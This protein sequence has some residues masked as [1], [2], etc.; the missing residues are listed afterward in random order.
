MRMSSRIRRLF[1]GS[2]L[3]DATIVPRSKVRRN[4]PRLDELED[5]TAPAVVT[6]DGGG[7]NLLWT[8]VANWSGNALPTANDEAVISSAAGTVVLTS[9]AVNVQS[10]TSSVGFSITGSASLT[11][12]L[13][14]SSVASLLLGSDTSLTATGATTT[15]TSAGSAA[16]DGARLFATAGASLALPGLISYTNAGGD[17]STAYFRADGPGSLLDLRNVASIAGSTAL[18]TTLSV[19]AINGGKVDLR[20]VANVADPI[21]GD[22]RGRATLFHADGLNSLVDL[23]ALTSFIDRAA[24]SVSGYP[25]YSRLQAT[26]NGTIQTPSLSVVSAAEILVDQTGHLSLPMLETLTASTFTDSF[27]HLDLPALESAPSSSFTVGGTNR[28]Y[29]LLASTIRASFT[30]NGVNVSLPALA[31]GSGGSFA[32]NGGGFSAP[33]L[34]NIDGASFFITGGST[35][36]ILAATDYINTNGDQSTAYFRADGLGSVLDLRNVNSIT[37][38]P[39]L[40]TTLNIEALN[41]GTVDLRGVVSIADPLGGDTRGRAIRAQ[42]NG[43]NSLV[44]LTALV[45]F[46]D[47]APDS[48][49][50]YPGYSGL[51]AT[52]SGTIQTPVVSVVSTAEILVDQAGHLSLPLLETLTG[53]SVTDSFGRLELPAL[54][55]APSSSFAV[56]GTNRTY[57]LLASATRAS[58]SINGVSVSVPALTNISGGSVSVNGGGFSAP[59]LSNIDGASFLIGG[60]SSV[61][62]LAATDYINTNGDLTTAYF[63]ADGL[64]SVLDLRNVNSITGST[65]LRTT[66]SI[67]ALNGG[68]VDLRGVSNITD[69]IGGDTRG[70]AVRVRADGLGSLVDLSALTSFVDRASDTVS[71]FPGYSSLQATNSGTILSPVLNIVNVAEILVDQTGHLSLPILATLTASLV[72]DS[73]GRL[74]LPALTTATSCSFTVGGT[75][76][77]YPLLASATS[78]SFVV[79][80]IGLS[81]PALTNSS[82]GS[83]TV[84]GGSLNVPLLS[85]I[86][87]ASFFISGGSTVA[88]LAATSYTNTNGDQT[89][90]YF[91]ADGPGSTLDLRNVVSITGSTAL[92]T[93]HSIEAFTGG[94]VDLRGVVNIADPIGGDTRGRATLVTADGL[95]SYVDLAAL[96][97]LVDRSTVPISGYAG[98]SYLSV[99]NNGTIRV[100]AT[101]ATISLGIVYLASG[102]SYIGS[103]GI[104]NGSVISGAGTIV[105]NVTNR[106]NIFPGYAG[107][108]GELSIT[109]NY[110]Q[111][112]LGVLTVDVGGIVP[113]IGFDL[114]SVGG[115]AT[116][117]NSLVRSVI[118]GF[119]PSNSD[120]YRIMTAANRVDIFTVNVGT[121]LGGNRFLNTFY[122]S[123]SV[124]LA[125][126][127]TRITITPTS[128]LTTS[129]TGDTATFLVALATE[130]T[131]DVLIPITS[132]DPTEGTVSTSLITITRSNWMVPQAVTVT[133]VYDGI[134]D[135]DQPYSVIVGVA[136]SLDL[137]YNGLDPADVQLT[138]LNAD[139]TGAFATVYVDPIWTGLSNGVIIPDADPAQPGNQQAVIG[140]T[141]HPSLN[142]AIQ[143]VISNGT[144]VV[145]S[146]VQNAL[147][148]LSKPF[149]LKVNG[150][151]NLLGSL[152]GSAGLTKIGNGILHLGVTNTYLGGTTVNQGTLRIANDAA[153]GTGPIV[154]NSLGTLEIV[155]NTASSRTFTLNSGALKIED[156][157]ALTLAD[158]SIGGGFLKGLGTIATSAGGSS[159]FAG[160]TSASSVTIQSNGSDSFSNFTHN[161]N[162]TISAGQTVTFDLFTSTSAGRVTVSAGAT[163]YALDFVSDGQ[164]T[165]NGAFWNVGASALIFGAGS[166]TT[167]NPGGLI[168]IGSIN[169]FGAIVAGGLVK[170]NGSFGSEFGSPIVVDYLGKVKGTGTFGSVVTQ[171]GGIF[172]PGA[173]PGTATTNKY[174]VNGGGIL[175]FE[176]SN[177]TGIAG[178]L[179]GWDLVVVQ[180]TEFNPAAGVVDITA[181]AASRYSILLSSRLDFG[182][183]IAP[184]AAANFNPSQPYAWKF[185]DASNALSSLSGTFDPS[186]FIVDASDFANPT[187]G[188]FAVELRD[189]GKNLYIVYTVFTSTMLTATPEAT[190]GGELVT[191]TAT[192]AP[193]PGN[194]GTINFLDNG[195]LIPGAGN[196]A[197]VGGVATFQTTLL[198]SG[199]H[200]LTAAYS[201]APGY[202]PSISP[203]INFSVTAAPTTVNLSL[204]SPNPATTLQDMSFT[205]FTSGGVLNNGESIIILDANHGNAVVPITGGVLL[206]GTTTVTVPAGSLT[207]GIHHLVAVYAG[208]SFNAGS[209]SSPVSQTVVPPPTSPQ[210]VSVT[211]NGNIASLAGDQRSRLVS[212]VVVFDQT[213]QLDS[214]AMALALHANNVALGGVPQPGGF[215]SLPTNLQISSADNIIWV[216]RFDGNTDP[217]APLFQPPGDGLNSLKDGVYDLNVVAS[218]VHP[219]GVPSVNGT[220][221]STTV[222]HRLFGD[223]NAPDVDGGGSNYTAILGISDNFAFRSSFNSVPNYRASFDYDGDGTIGVQDNFQFRSR[224]NRPLTWSV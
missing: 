198:V 110:T 86:D 74:D 135:G 87:G 61:A 186:K 62:L 169:G 221:N 23:S 1:C 208:N 100:S 197:L 176:V 43:L 90:T 52:N 88:V 168:D 82:D 57:P 114:V 58:F 98:Q 124:D 180:P 109:G 64:G 83:F 149:L 91:R 48:V 92:R 183:R 134:V 4:V 141:A 116:L 22:T 195:V 94:K 133:G 80:G 14:S 164:L 15:F 63:R 184:G 7:S 178:N 150:T 104:Q 30:I 17:L 185:A 223:A 182:D 214:G 171:N 215:G 175:E 3:L 71:G 143:A 24:D 123:T 53:S 66:L 73:T 173:S 206:G 204:G 203:V 207:V 34:S 217:G 130:P 167:I 28:T 41:C 5:R 29:P 10:L 222:F 146:G 38:S 202:A 26:N 174:N 132:G 165:T 147:A 21:G 166:V 153:L 120:V 172:A 209:Q 54:A 79:N 210:I 154:V 117:A 157:V 18:R 218:K 45:S 128:G 49:S 193:S 212:L 138:N 106:G 118:G 78:T 25:G 68:K 107:S 35:V 148:N 162:L 113:G 139:F 200:P 75:N 31:D 70:R 8:T 142:P 40:R 177:A 112:E 60:G 220:A 97:A 56:G 155:G 129:E 137:T 103:F 81:L 224:F 205:V 6:W 201:G 156:N 211:P 11:V 12:S 111:T 108:I 140:T 102:G 181:T 125:V 119:V 37:G 36:A 159:N 85:N 131:E 99:S 39:A 95:N 89:L 145:N 126:A 136:T 158:A 72:T 160:V 192:V 213:V 69:P 44:D 9:G 170:N 191:L 55:S 151:V 67:E 163:A 50:G 105:G 46:T 13:G 196:L 77:T 101:G 96:T 20:A 84:N 33:L 19:E 188:A 152:I 59:L 115:T 122:T 32:V 51:L 27:G 65:T 216:I 127:P 121:A 187:S 161:G 219:L 189:G 179:S 42:A 144:V 194:L 16:I 76:R 199:V 190:T 2:R 47:S 93:T